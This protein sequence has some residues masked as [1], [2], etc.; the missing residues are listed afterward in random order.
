MDEI[1]RTIEE[2][3]ETQDPITEFSGVSAMILFEGA[4][5]A[6]ECGEVIDRDFSLVL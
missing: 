3:K 5:K 2:E 6:R 4:E 1:V